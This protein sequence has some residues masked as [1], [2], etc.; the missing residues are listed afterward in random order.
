MRH[1]NYSN[2]LVH[3]CA[4]PLCFV[5]PNAVPNT[6]CSSHKTNSL[7]SA[8]SVCSQP[9]RS[10]ASKLPKGRPAKARVLASSEGTAR[11]TAE[12]P[13]PDSSTA[14]R[15]TFSESNVPQKSTAA[16]KR[17]PVSIV[18]LESRVSNVI[19]DKTTDTPLCTSVQDI[20][21]FSTG[22]IANDMKIELK[23]FDDSLVL[24]PSHLKISEEK[25]AL[26]K[27]LESNEWCNFDIKQENEEL[28]ISYSPSEPDQSRCQTVRTCDME[29]YAN[30]A[31]SSLVVVVKTLTLTTTT[32]SVSKSLSSLVISPGVGSVIDGGLLKNNT[33][34]SSHFRTCNSFVETPLMNDINRSTGNRSDAE[35]IVTVGGLTQSQETFALKTADILSKDH[36]RVKLNTK[37][38]SQTQGILDKEA[39]QLKNLS[40]SN[41]LSASNVILKVPL[42][43]IKGGKMSPRFLLCK[44]YFYF[45]HF[46]NSFCLNTFNLINYHLCW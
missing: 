25:E 18:A 11:N 39:E 33:K 9:G 29:S 26:V 1:Q 4:L 31:N 20:S 42:K 43:Q 14:L 46:L 30:N 45:V 44:G 38:Q 21:S 34:Y 23:D 8:Q 40:E 19:L 6:K 35:G 13:K 2:S 27:L 17:N 12:K 41:C 10:C 32:C 28:G 7:T 5:N 22:H 16:V 24:E 36:D 3:N 15:G 37:T